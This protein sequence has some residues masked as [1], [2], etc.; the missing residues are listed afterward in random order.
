M[1]VMGEKAAQIKALN[2]TEIELF[3]KEEYLHN[4]LINIEDL[5]L[6]ELTI[7]RLKNLKTKSISQVLNKQNQ[8]KSLNLNN[9]MTFDECHKT[10]YLLRSIFDY[11]NGSHLLVDTLESLKLKSARLE[12]DL[13]L[14]CELGKFT[15]LKCLD[16]SQCVFQSK[17]SNAKELQIFTKNLAT[18]LSNCTR[19]ET[20]ILASCEVLVDDYFVKTIAYRMRKLTHLDLRNCSKITDASLHYIC[21]Y[22]SEL[23]YLD[24]SWAPRLSDHGF[25]SSLDKASVLK[26][27]TSYKSH[28]SFGYCRCDI[29][30][31]QLTNVRQVS[32]KRL[33]DVEEPIEE[34]D[35]IV[36]RPGVNVNDLKMIKVLKIEACD[37][38]TDAS[39]RRFFEMDNLVE[40]DL[41]L[42]TNLKGDFVD[43][44]S[45]QRANLSRLNLN[46]CINVGEANLIRVLKACLHLR[47]LGASGCE[48]MTNNVMNYL[49]ESRSVLNRLDVSYCTSVSESVVENYEQFLSSEFALTEFNIEKKFI[50]RK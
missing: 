47:E 15:N 24:V 28:T 43:A 20:L 39:V 13:F 27:E 5:Q 18:H 12:S 40:L 46:K 1:Y 14:L 7:E 45:Q 26:F 37:N 10:D 33:S 11:Q 21:T 42:C 44:D 3:A 19:M 9:S 31:K 32:L 16:L 17:F 25:D 48:G 23:T 41:R 34:A 6:E 30:S 49:M 38:L 2:L 29:C 8:L 4:L 22:L 35:E 50:S 36:V